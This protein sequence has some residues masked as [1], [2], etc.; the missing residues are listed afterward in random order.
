MQNNKTLLHMVTCI[1]LVVGGLNWLL[2]GLFGWEVGSFLPGGMQGVIAKIIYILV[3]L[4]AIYE[5]AT[6][7]Q[8]CQACAAMGKPTS[9]PPSS[10]MPGM[11][12][13]NK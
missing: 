3:G 13:M 10:G 4:S 6:H 9:T 1:L 5:I 2:F 7:K 8:N 12:G 11:P